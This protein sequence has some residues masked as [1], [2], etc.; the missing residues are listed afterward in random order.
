MME[1]LP[2]TVTEQLT[3]MGREFQVQK[4][5]NLNS[6]KSTKNFVKYKKICFFRVNLSISCRFV[7]I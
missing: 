5:G 1:A 6:R 2:S 7:N 3:R 4:I